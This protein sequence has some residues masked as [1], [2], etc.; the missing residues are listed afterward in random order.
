MLLFLL[1]VEWMS[2]LKAVGLFGIVLFLVA[3]I[4][5]PI[6]ATV[7]VGV[8]LANMLGFS[9]LLWWCFV[10]LF[11]LVIMGVLRALSK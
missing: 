8:A 10:V 9:G 11:Y 3:V 5:V 7:V 2:F 4:V 6:V 1:D